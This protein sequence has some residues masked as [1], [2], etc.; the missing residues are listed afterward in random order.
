M[1]AYGLPLDQ[2]R[3]MLEYAAMKRITLIFLFVLAYSASIV[4]AQDEAG[5]I[6]GRMNALRSGKGLPAYSVNGSLTAAAQSQAQWLVDNGE[7]F[8]YVTSRYS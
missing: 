8:E 7:R 4:V 1:P 5:D 2:K 3:N 6:V